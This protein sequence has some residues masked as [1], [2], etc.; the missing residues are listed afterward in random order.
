VHLVISGEGKTDIGSASYQ[1]DEFIAG[2]MYYIID[3]LI[4][5]KCSF[6]PYECYQA[7]ADKS[8]W[9]TF[10]DESELV[11]FGK[12]NFSG[13]KKKGT[14]LPGKKKEQDTGEFY[15]NARALARIAHKVGD[16]KSDNNIIAILFRDKDGKRTKSDAL[17]QSKVRSMEDGFK[18]EEFDFGVPMVPNPKSEAWL[19]CALKNTPYQQ[20]EKLEERSGND[21]SPNNLKDELASFGITNN[22]INSMIQSG[23]I[24]LEKINMP[25]FKYFANRLKELL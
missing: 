9:I 3:K 21:D 18:A 1:S 23:E 15:V 20:C 16:E 14:T 11:K 12:S 2:S 10:V 19:I 4:E 6:S 25:S 17:W 24:K 8:N 22:Q 7:D 13:Y 5:E